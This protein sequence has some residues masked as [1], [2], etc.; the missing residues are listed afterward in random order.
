LKSYDYELLSD[1]YKN[2]KQLL[3]MIC[4]K[5]HALSMRWND[6]QTGHRCSI[7]FKKPKY[8][9][10]YVKKTI[11]K[12]G[13][14][15]LS[16]EYT[17]N[18]QALDIICN[19]GYTY[20]AS[21]SVWCSQKQRCPICG[22]KKSSEKQRHSYEKIVSDFDSIGYKLK[23]S[24]Y[25]NN[26]QILSVICDKGHRYDFELKLNDKTQII[27]YNTGRLLELD[28]W[29]PEINK[30]I[31]YNGTYWHKSNYVKIKDEIKK[32]KCIE[33]GIDLLVIDEND[34]LSNKQSVLDNINMF[35]NRR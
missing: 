9:Y 25:I 1:E 14:K 28:F 7:C 6:F 8:E 27:N 32:R 30:A 2:N 20:K 21:F 10:E 3:N 4:D 26:R 22:D 24:E 11:E 12:D 33:R 16:K 34:W 5:G 19:C 17:N 31:E 35:I 18:K 23:S 29:F 13:Y 15:L